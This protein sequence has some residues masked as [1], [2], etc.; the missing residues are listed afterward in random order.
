MCNPQR[1]HG[2]K[3]TVQKS[4][5]NPQSSHVKA[6]PD[7]LL[8]SEKESSAQG[9][10]FKGLGGDL[11]NGT[12]QRP[13][14]RPAERASINPTTSSSA[15]AAADQPSAATPPPPL[16]PP[17]AEEEESCTSPE[18]G[19][20]APEEPGEGDADAVEDDSEVP[21]S[22]S[23]EVIY[24]DVPT[25]YHP[26]SPDEEDV[27]YEDV[28]RGGPVSADN[29]WS[30]S[31]FE[32]Y[33]DQSDN[34]AKVPT[35]TKLSPEVRGLRERCARTKRE[36]ASR[37]GA[38][39]DTKVQQFM[40]AA[41]SGTK[42]GLEKTRMAVMR[43]VSFLQKKDHADSHFPSV[44][45]HPPP[46]LFSKSMVLDVY[47]DYVNNFTNAMALIKKACISKPAFLDFLKR[48][49]A[50]SVDRITL[51]GLMVKPIQRFPQFILLLQDMLKNTPRGHVDRLPL[52][53][54]L[55]ELE[56]LAEKLNEQKRQADQVA[57]TQ[58]LARSVG[59][60]L[61]SKS[62]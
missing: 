33:D 47:S 8:N 6:L 21:H 52:Q 58:Q 9:Q 13:R 20:P 46:Y 27:I 59:D 39:Y 10:E 2:N 51:Y 32:D 49:Q 36:L 60:R 26:L 4:Q 24:D 18:E 16:P 56:T 7:R 41:K 38:N 5:M 17:T 57:E 19:S 48:K 55:T 43:K 54:A 30:S 12:G 3:E 62:H 22:D 25:E 15:A 37:L 34:E 40:K 50:S 35:R 11:Q 29:G 28:Q 1:F 23:L 44:L 61:L 14:R 45:I 31:E 53:L 42:D